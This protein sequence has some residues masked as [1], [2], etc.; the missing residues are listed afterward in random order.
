MTLHLRSHF[1][2]HSGG[3]SDTTSTCGHA[4][5]LRSHFPPYSERNCDTKEGLA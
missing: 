4:P 1:P 3:N 5:P 2:P